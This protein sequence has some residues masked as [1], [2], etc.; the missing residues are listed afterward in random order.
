M[1]ALRLQFTDGV[2]SRIQ[3]FTLI[4]VMVATGLLVTI[5]LGTAQLFALATGH[6]LSARHQLLMTVAAERKI[7]ELAAA[8]ARGL[9]AI[10]PSGTLDRDI[11]G[12]VDRPAEGGGV[13]LRRW[14][15]TPVLGYESEALAIVVRVV[16]PARTADVQLTAIVS[17]GPL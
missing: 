17:R 7:D 16:P 13:Y 12:F 4:E 5:A 11:A 1:L 8:A 10:A 6:T 15:V 14:C 3:G 2:H 9:V